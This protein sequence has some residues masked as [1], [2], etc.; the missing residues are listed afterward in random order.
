MLL[1][2]INVAY[3]QHLMQGMREAVA[4]GTFE[5][6]RMQTRAGWARG[7]IPLR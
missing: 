7:D 6:F 1:S 5:T 4:G 2:E 3:Y